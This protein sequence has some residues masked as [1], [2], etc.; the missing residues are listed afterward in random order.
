M[1]QNYKADQYSLVYAF[2]NKNE[3]GDVYYRICSLS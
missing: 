2:A 1:P 3:L